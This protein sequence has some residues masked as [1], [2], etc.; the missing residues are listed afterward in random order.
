MKV[1]YAPNKHAKA[2]APGLRPGQVLEVDKDEAKR[3]LATGAFEAV[4]GPKGRTK[5]KGGKNA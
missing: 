1:R 3:L 4:E 5:K 2:F